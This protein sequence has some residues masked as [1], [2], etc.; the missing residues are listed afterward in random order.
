MSEPHL[1]LICL[2]TVNN[3]NFPSFLL[4]AVHLYQLLFSQFSL[5]SPPPECFSALL[6][7]FTPLLPSLHIH[8][9]F[10]QS[11]TRN[12]TCRPSLMLLCFPGNPYIGLCVCKPLSNASSAYTHTCSCT[13]TYT[14]TQRKAP[15]HNN[16]FK[17]FRLADISFFF[18]FFFLNLS[19]FSKAFLKF[20]FFFFFFTSNSCSLTCVTFSL[21]S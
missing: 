9:R 3:P 17:G 18:F 5:S 1:T 20:Y 11:D 4:F 13:H 6:R 12:S 15:P 16:P 21:Q 10:Q 7:L 14:H 19:T 8:R 2:F